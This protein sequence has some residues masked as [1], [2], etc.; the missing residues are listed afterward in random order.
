MQREGSMSRMK[1]PSVE[2]MDN[3]DRLTDKAINALQSA[4][5]SAWERHHRHVAPEHLLLALA[6]MGLN[7]AA[8]ILEMLGVHLC[9]EIEDL[10]MMLAVISPEAQ[11]GE[12][13]AGPAMNRTL[14]TAKAASVALGHNW[15][16]TEH[17][18]LG[19]LACQGT[20]AREFLA[21]RGVTPEKVREA[22]EVMLGRHDYRF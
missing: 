18:L 8:G 9:R 4:I 21:S 16:G 13:S 7:F 2:D 5:T 19:M 17:L 11:D 22:I 10:S 6:Q 1:L 14:E 3:P 15:V 12:P 20:P